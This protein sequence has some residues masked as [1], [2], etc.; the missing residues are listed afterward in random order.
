M[1][2]QGG[3]E[4]VERGTCLVVFRVSSEIMPNVTNSGPGS[5]FA[6]G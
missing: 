2:L 3:A 4:V 1:E 5:S 6:C